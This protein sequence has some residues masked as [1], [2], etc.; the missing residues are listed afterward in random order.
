[1]RYGGDDDA[2]CVNFPKSLQQVGVRI[3]RSSFARSVSA[4]LPREQ[5]RSQ[6]M[7]LFF[8]GSVRIRLGHSSI[9]IDSFDV[10]RSEPRTLL[11]RTKEE[12]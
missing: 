12:M 1:M 4:N 9:F 2:G 6:V 11:L 7:R 10:R 3:P 8:S 5:R